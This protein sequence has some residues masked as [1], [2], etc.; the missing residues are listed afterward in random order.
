VSWY[1]L[2]WHHHAIPKQAFILWLA[3]NNRLTTGDR[4]L[5]W[6][7]KGDTSCVF[8]R[9]MTECRDHIFFLLWVQ[10]S[11]LEGLLPAM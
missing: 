10:F 7:F 4:L 3:V 6:G 8:C 9:G 11:D 1:S 5:A 2:I